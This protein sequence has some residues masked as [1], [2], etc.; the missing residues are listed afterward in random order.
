MSKTELLIALARCTFL[1]CAEKEFLAKKLDNLESLT[2]LSIEDICVMVSRNVRTRLWNPKEL[3]YL[4]DR[5]M[6]SMKR[7]DIHFVT[8]MDGEY[9]PLLREIHDPPF[10]LFWRGTLPDPERPLAAIVGT[11]APSG[12]GALA[13]ARLGRDFAEFGVPVISG[14]ARGIDAF[15]H[16]GNMEG[17]GR[18]VAVLACG[19]DQIYPRSNA[20]LASRIIGDGGCLLAEYAP[21]E[22]PLK[23]RFPERNRIISGLARAVLIVEAPDKSGALITADFALEQGRD[24]FI[25]SGTFDSSRNAGCRRLFSEGAPMA[26]CARD[27]L[28]SWRLPIHN[29]NSAIGKMSANSDCGVRSIPDIRVSACGSHC[30]PSAVGKQLAFEFGKELDLMGKSR[31]VE[32]N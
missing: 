30:D 29:R 6:L 31:S 12:T 32:E 21:G 2:V 11:R 17:F 25:Y 13:A 18:S 9:P 14:L 26:Y 27:I 5:D 16:R 7:Y 23:F 8:I 4:V 20:R 15:A 10:A 24:L 3:P 28:A 19:V 22:G 1:S